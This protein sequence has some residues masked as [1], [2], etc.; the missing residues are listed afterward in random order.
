MH[1]GPTTMTLI[2]FSVGWSL[3]TFTGCFC[4]GD[5]LLPMR[6]LR[7]GVGREVRKTQGA[8]EP[9]KGGCILTPGGLWNSSLLDASSAFL[10]VAPINHWH[11]SPVGGEGCC[12]PV[13]FLDSWAVF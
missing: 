5:M 12:L 13:H 6:T 7:E 2:D 10:Y 9:T 8:F 1:M 3:H 4:Y 11:E